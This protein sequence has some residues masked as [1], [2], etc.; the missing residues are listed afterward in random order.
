[1]RIGKLDGLR[2]LAV[3]LVI[4]NHIFGFPSSGYLG[5]DIFF[6][7]SGF[8]ITKVL[9]EARD[10]NLKI[11]RFLSH[12]YGRRM[13]RILPPLVV[14]VFLLLLT[15]YIEGDPAR[16][17]F[18]QLKYV[19]TFTLNLRFSSQGLLYEGSRLVQN[20]P[21]SHLWSLAVEE[22]FYLVWPLIIYFL[23]RFFLKKP[24]IL[25]IPIFISLSLLFFNITEFNNS[26]SYYSS[27]CRYY[28]IILGA[29]T[30]YLYKKTE[31]RKPLLDYLAITT[32]FL[33]TLT[34]E[35]HTN[36]FSSVKG[37]FVAILTS[38]ILLNKRE[39]NLLKLRI[40]EYIGLRSYGLYLYHIPVAHLFLKIDN[41][42]IGKLLSLAMTF[43]LAEVSYKLI[44]SPILKIKNTR[45]IIFSGITV[46]ISIFA[47]SFLSI[48]KP[49]SWE[50]ASFK[51]VARDFCNIESIQC[52]GPLK[53][54]DNAAWWNCAER[55]N[56]GFV[57]PIDCPIYESKKPRGKI[58]FM[59]D[60]VGQSFI[61]GII[62]YAKIEN[63]SIYDGSVKSCGWFANNMDTNSSPERGNI[64]NCKEIVDS[65]VKYAVNKVKP[66][67]Y[68]FTMNPA[69]R[70]WNP[71]MGEDGLKE[72][73][74]YMEKYIEIYLKNKNAKILLLK[75]PVY[76]EAKSCSNPEYAVDK[77]DKYWT[78]NHAEKARKIE[79][80]LYQ[81]LARENPSRVFYLDTTSG[82]C[83]PDIDHCIWESKYGPTRSS[84]VHL[85]FWL[86][87]LY[88]RTL[89]DESMK[90]L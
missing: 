9:V 20:S 23:S 55:Y 72:T 27:V 28:Q 34:A 66:D 10:K 88:G 68:I 60:S 37:L 17:W 4:T 64:A 52:V 41:S 29:L 75:P 77:C 87:H 58:I 70:Y 61:P 47:V 25:L 33:I 50:L 7:I 24:L 79:G 46:L 73:K 57:T 45:I 59:G 40:L 43:L 12:F 15:Y 78:V 13:A 2:A 62:P 89:L 65:S 69:S 51:N 84:Q 49:I 38:L 67:L 19:A 54:T 14:T 39:N 76:L 18:S 86:S 85:T 35:I 44:E 6:V 83:I 48:E 1:M 53:A 42:I 71:E 22:Q 63:I 82:T 74:K 81:A 90:Y 30:Y 31:I 36:L 11:K 21:I 5:V 56:V 3:L 8:I 16:V 80:D 32:I 26:D